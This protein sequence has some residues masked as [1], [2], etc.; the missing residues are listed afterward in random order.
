[1]I[2]LTGGS[3]RLGKELLKI[4]PNT[5]APS[6][7]EF[8]VTGVI[9][10]HKYDLVIHAA[11]YTN[12]AQAELRKKDC[13]ILNVLGTMQ[14]AVFSYDSPF[15]YI[16]SE[17]ANNPVNYY[18]KTKQ[19]AEKHLKQVY[20]K[21]LIIRTL[22]KVRPFPYPTA[23]TDQYTQGDY[24]DVIAPLI[25][26]AIDEWDKKTPKIIYVGTERKT[27]FDLAKRTR[28]DVQPISVDDI[29]TVRVPKDYI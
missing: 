4:M 29:M 11:G 19:L 6:H 15:V 23:Y 5:Y 7:K 12:V 20:K 27:M 18:G 10:Y 25:K 9:P 22:F 24:V 14:L 26:K 1:M 28:P 3:G 17:Y 21:C 2:L 8:D 13:Y 16:S